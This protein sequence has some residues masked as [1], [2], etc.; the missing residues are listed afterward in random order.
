MAASHTIDSL[1]AACN[2]CEIKY[3]GKQYMYMYIYMC[4]CVCVCK[5][6]KHLET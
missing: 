4:V 6:K 1:I 5:N 2:D 3:V